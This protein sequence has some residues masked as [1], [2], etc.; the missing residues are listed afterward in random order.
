MIYFV[1]NSLEQFKAMDNL[2]LNNSIQNL[3]IDWFISREKFSQDLATYS[4]L[5]KKLIHLKQTVC[6]SFKLFKKILRKCA[7]QYMDAPIVTKFKICVNDCCLFQSRYSHNVAE[8]VKKYVSGVK[9][10]EWTPPLNSAYW[11]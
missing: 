10:K 11:N 8:T 4:F 9:Q 5:S 6:L 2:V 7:K 1:M 3:S